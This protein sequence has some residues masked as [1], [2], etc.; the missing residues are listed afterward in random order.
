MAAGSAPTDH[1]FA[2]GESPCFAVVGHP[3][4]GKS[5]IVSTLT[6]D[7][8]VTIG[9]RPGTT[10]EAIAYPMR[11]DGEVLYT[12]ID[13]P[14]FQRAREV[15]AW[16]EAHDDGVERRRAT[17]ERFVS[18]HREDPR[19]TDECALLTPLL[20]GAGILY[21]VDGSR[22]YGT[23]YEPEMEILRRTGQPRMALIN[24]ISDGDHLHD[25]TLA[26]DQYFSIVR[27][28]NA[29]H[30]DFGKRIEL[31]RAFGQLSEHWRA[32]LDRAADSLAAERA[33][34]R[35]QSATEIAA[36]L[37]EVYSLTRQR[38]LPFEASRPEL[39]NAT[40]ELT[41]ALRRQVRER[42]RD[43]RHRVQRLYGH[44]GLRTAE[45]DALPLDRDPFSEESWQLFG[46]SRAQLLSA[47]VASGATAGGAIDLA[48]GGSSLLLGAGIGSLVSGIGAWLGGRQL[49]RTRVAGMSLGGRVLTVGPVGDPNLA[50]VLLNRA[51]LHHRL[52]SERNHALRDQLVIDFAD[53]VPDAPRSAPE[54]AR[55]LAR[56]T[57]RTTPDDR[58]AA[59][60]RDAIEARLS[61][62]ESSAEPTAP[63]AT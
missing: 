16:L 17:V 18:E 42:E 3:N 12:L 8:A 50:W 34:R 20:A 14:G 33:R 40:S 59:Q 45:A 27:V 30:A 41:E 15:L 44:G 24:L 58:L 62:A 56:L 48:V 60:L 28:F 32:R 55:L 36:L 38:T 29:Q 5:S 61:A 52:V 39:E 26:L 53:R 49:A 22:P 13:T 23:A 25:W 37:T 43:S 4:K 51:M 6:E 10:R 57:G 9:T 1:H 2:Q 21:V 54:L 63:A 31:L 19:F 46:L 35:R 47:A 11:L 7:V